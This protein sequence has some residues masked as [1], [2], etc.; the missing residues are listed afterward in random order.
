MHEAG[1]RFDRYGLSSPMEAKYS[2]TMAFSPLKFEEMHFEEL[3]S[4]S[5]PI[6][7]VSLV[8]N[9]DCRLK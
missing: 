5:V 9:F 6:K 4:R 7:S 8:H 1:H 2:K 3:G